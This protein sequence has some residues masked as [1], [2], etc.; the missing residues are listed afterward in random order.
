MRNSDGTQSLSLVEVLRDLESAG[1][2]A[3]LAARDGEQ[4]HCGACDETSAATDFALGPLQRTEG[5]SD[6]AD[7]SA[8]VGLTCPRC[9]EKGVLILRYGPEADPADAG[10]MAA[11]EA[12][13]D[14]QQHHT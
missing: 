7:M 3:D 5:E 14:A 4:V 6:P 9:G 8:V 11:L 1:F 2:T 12:A 10:V 13:R